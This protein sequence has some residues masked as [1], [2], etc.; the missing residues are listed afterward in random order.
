MTN[1][2]G[3]GNNSEQMGIE[4][5]GMEDLAGQ[6]YLYIC[7]MELKQIVVS[8]VIHAIKLSDLESSSCSC[9]D[10]E[11]PSRSCL[12]REP[13]GILHP[14][15][16]KCPSC[17]KGSSELHYL[18]SMASEDLPGFMGCGVFQSKILFAGS[19]KPRIPLRS[20][21][22]SRKSLSKYSC[23]ERFGPALYEQLHGYETNQTNRTLELR[24]RDDMSKN[25]S[26]K[27]QP[28]RF[29]PPLYKTNQTTEVRV[30]D[31]MSKNF[32]P[33]AQPL[34]VELKGKLYALS[35]YFGSECHLKPPYFQVF[36]PEDKD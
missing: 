22:L 33:K 6:E 4:G 15:I 7:S 35:G 3:S 10:L 30:R 13:I 34:L 2:R 8:Y 26:R 5:G 27:A 28:V 14:Y 21:S 32:S 1:K 36:D 11:S 18:A 25:F 29:R 31:D 12:H 24:A 16:D 19:V 17:S 20:W 9:S 23:Y